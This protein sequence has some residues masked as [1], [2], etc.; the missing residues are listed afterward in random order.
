LNWIEFH[1]KFFRGKGYLFE[2]LGFSMTP[3]ED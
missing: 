2:P 1:S 3:D